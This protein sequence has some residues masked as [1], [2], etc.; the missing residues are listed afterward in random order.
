MCHEPDCSD[1]EAASDH[2]LS[3]DL[4]KNPHLYLYFWLHTSQF[5]TFP[6][7]NNWNSLVRVEQGDVSSELVMPRCLVK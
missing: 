5:P 4:H 3:Q 2:K 1:K 7:A 6:R